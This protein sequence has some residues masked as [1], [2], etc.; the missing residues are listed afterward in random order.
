MRRAEAVRAEWDGAVDGGRRF[1]VAGSWGTA[2]GVVASAPVRHG[3]RLGR[4]SDQAPGTVALVAPA[5][6]G[7]EDAAPAVGLDDALAA[8]LL[9]AGCGVARVLALDHAQP[10]DVEA[11]I[12]AIVDISVAA[13]GSAR[14]ALAGS[15]MAGP[16]CALAASR[17]EGLAFV[18]LASAPSAEVMARRTPENE[19]DPAWTESRTLRL[20][21]A[22]AAMAPLE[23]VCMDERPVLV[24]GGAADGV[25]PVTHLEAWRA[26]LEAN[27]RPVQAIEVAFHDAFMR[28][29]GPG[30]GDDGTG[31]GLMAHTVEQWARRALSR[32]PARRAT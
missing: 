18:V 24:V 31:L 20:A 15:W 7:L 1:S 2:S 4:R 28:P 30:D 6:P 12:D 17:R 16:A 21:D 19:D 27:Q 26:A 14:P 8:G 13:T 9:R 3:F 5:F 32:A 29:V 23:A 22:L 10:G 11:W 25:L